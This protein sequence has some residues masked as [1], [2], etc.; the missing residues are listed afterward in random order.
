MPHGAHQLGAGAIAAG[1][2]DAVAAVPGLAAERGNAG[3][4]AVEFDAEA[5]QP[6][7]PFRG[8]AGDECG[9][10]GFREARRDTQG[11]GRVLGRG[12]IAIERSGDPALRKP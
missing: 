7:D 12:I 2:D 8:R 9:D 4:L 3:R 11:V 6:V 1:M 10:I 5:A